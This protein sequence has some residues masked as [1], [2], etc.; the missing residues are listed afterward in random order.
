[1][2]RVSGTRLIIG[3]IVMGIAV[4]LMIFFL[5]HLDS[6][7]QLF[8]IAA[9]TLLSWGAADLLAKILERPR[10]RDRSPGRALGEEFD[11]RAKE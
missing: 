8:T 3:V 1:M 11:R 7:S 4:P 6:L 5:L 9:C 10:L 2:S